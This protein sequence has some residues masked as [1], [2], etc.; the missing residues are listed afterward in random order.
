MM[1]DKEIEELVQS[2]NEGKDVTNNSIFRIMVALNK[3]VKQLYQQT[4]NPPT[5]NDLNK[6]INDL[7]SRISILE[8]KIK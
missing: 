1:D 8:S 7:S 2:I 5:N 6:S 4:Y 3:R